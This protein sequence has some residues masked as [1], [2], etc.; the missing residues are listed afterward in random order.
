MAA[1]PPKSF[2]N[3]MKV[4]LLGGSFPDLRLT[5]AANSSSTSKPRGGGSRS[6]AMRDALSDGRP[7]G[8]GGV[9]VVDNSRNRQPCRE[10]FKT[11]SRGGPRPTTDFEP[12]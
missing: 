5:F 8:S 7:Q 4:D 1:L 2:A 9:V 3:G 6:R 10:N 11:R 12:P